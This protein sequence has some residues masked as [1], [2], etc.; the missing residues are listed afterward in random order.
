MLVD[1][2]ILGLHVDTGIN[3]TVGESRVSKAAYLTC[4][5]VK[6]RGEGVGGE[7]VQQL[8]LILGL[9]EWFVIGG[10]G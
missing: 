2:H 4:S 6:E 8:L 5:T 9:E 10:S 3:S 1:F 7:G